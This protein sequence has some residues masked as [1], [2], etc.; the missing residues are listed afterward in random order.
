M[1]L[2][3]STLKL[4]ID[5]LVSI[6]HNFRK[7]TGNADLLSYYL[8]LNKL[9]VSNSQW[10]DK[11]SIFEDKEK[12]LHSLWQL[13]GLFSHTENPKKRC[14][15]LLSSFSKKNELSESHFYNKSTVFSNLTGRFKDTID[16]TAADYLLDKGRNDTYRFKTDVVEVINNNYTGKFPLEAIVLWVFREYEFVTRLSL[17]ELIRVF[18]GEFNL[19]TLEA[20]KLFTISN[21]IPIVFSE[22]KV[23][24]SLIRDYLNSD[25]ICE[26]SEQ[27]LDTAFNFYSNTTI[28]TSLYNGTNM[29]ITPEKVQLLL[30]KNKQIVLTGVPGTGKSFMIN[31]IREA[32]EEVKII[33]FHQNYSYQD[34][35]LGKTIDNGDVK[36]VKGDLVEFVSRLDPEKKYLL[37]LDEINRGN[38]SS[39]FGEA[40]YALDRGNEIVLDEEHS[41]CLPDNLHILGTMNT[42]DRSIALIDFAI[43]RRFLFAELTPDYDLIDRDVKI[44]DKEV[45]GDFLRITNEK[46]IEQFENS[47]YILGHSY[48]LSTSIEGADDV[49]D[50]IHYK[51]VPMLVE[52][53][54]GDRSIL[55]N[56]FPESLLNANSVDLLTEIESYINE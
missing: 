54:H 38:I 2:C 19:T 37:V 43:R 21:S 49:Y 9:N 48:F 27:V 3:E 17:Q 10:I 31:Q 25:Q 7:S 6:E 8:I 32:Y 41:L 55:T 13:G 20:R 5:K 52:Y 28:S 29:S 35:V 14:C 53:G 16:N 44:N 24:S 50:I 18:L 34:F 51:I 22:D 4:A 39:I 45:L 56:I 12:I 23:N 1:F 47:D 40:L 36:V 30:N 46:I 42:A 15:L 26:I 11:A 33:Q